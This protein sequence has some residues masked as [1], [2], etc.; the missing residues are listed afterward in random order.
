MKRDYLASLTN[1]LDEYFSRYADEIDVAP[2]MRFSNEGYIQAGLDLR[3]MTAEELAGLKQQAYRKAFKAI[4]DRVLSGLN[5][6]CFL[7]AIMKRAPV[8][9][10]SSS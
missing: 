10:S 8:K 3:L 4:D 9:P 6:D 7:P 1:R 5:G 2:A